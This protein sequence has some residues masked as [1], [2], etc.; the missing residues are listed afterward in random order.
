MTPTRTAAENPPATDA[1]SGGIDLTKLSEDFERDG[2][3]GPFPALDP[4]H[5]SRVKNALETIVANDF[6][7]PLYGRSSGRDWHLVHPDILAMVK[8]PAVVGVLRPLLGDDLIVWRSQIFNKEPGDGRLQWHQAYLF[9]GEEYGNEK[10][11]LRPPRSERFEDWFD[12][13]IWFAVDDAVEENGAVQL[14][15]GTYRTRYPTRAVPFEESVFGQSLLPHLR[16]TGQFE[17]IAEL[18]GRTCLQPTFDPEREGTGVHVMEV[19]AGHFFVFNERTEH[20]SG[21][22]LTDRRRLA[23]NFRITTPDTVVYPFRL[24]GDFQDGEDYDISRHGCFLISGT[25][26]FRRNV[27]FSDSYSFHHR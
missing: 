6:Q 14:A 17:R 22:N 10:H 20:C 2:F 13:S 8:H 12:L 5:L 19:P 11:A 21:P 15:P 3:A 9:S 23:I 16:R 25:D 27:V 26:R 24:D 1:G 7:S 18:T 4:D